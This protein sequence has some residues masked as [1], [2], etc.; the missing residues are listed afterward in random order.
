M[1]TEATGSH[2]GWGSVGHFMI[3]LSKL[4]EPDF[5]Y[6]SGILHYSLFAVSLWGQ[7]VFIEKRGFSFTQLHSQHFCFYEHFISSVSRWIFEILEIFYLGKHCKTAML[8]LNIRFIH[9][10]GGHGL[11]NCGPS[12][13]LGTVGRGCKAHGGNFSMS[14]RNS[15]VKTDNWSSEGRNQI[16]GSWKTDKNKR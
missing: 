7:L 13:L 12:N 11:T 9:S 14:W 15:E 6:N 3:N 4:Q 8:P 10:F 1:I 16:Q 2:W 5:I